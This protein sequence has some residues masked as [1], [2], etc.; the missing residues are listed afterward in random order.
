MKE[1]REIINGAKLT[2][3]ARELTLRIFDILSEAEA[4][5]HGIPKEE[6]HFHEVGAVDSIVDITAAAVCIDDL[7]NGPLKVERVIVPALY[8]GGGTVRTQHGILPVPVPAVLNVVS[9][10]HIPL[11][12][13]GAQGEYVTPTGAAF[14]AAVRCEGGLP[15]RFSVKK[16]GLGAGKRKQEGTGILRALLIE[17]A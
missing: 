5:A 2:D 9:E 13:T 6:V 7:K 3:G 17:E 16:T 11:E 12:L 1:I 15:E 10:H 4:K 14:V 8:E